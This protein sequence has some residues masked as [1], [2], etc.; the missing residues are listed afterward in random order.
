MGMEISKNCE[1]C[2]KFKQGS[3]K[4]KKSSPKIE[5]YWGTQRQISLSG[6]D[7]CKLYEFDSRLYVFAD[8]SGKRET[9]RDAKQRGKVKQEVADSQEAFDD[10]DLG[11]SLSSADFEG[12]I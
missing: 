5:K 1:E 12:L 8:G 6:L 10:F 7:F 3:C 2:L 4:G 9:F 11:A